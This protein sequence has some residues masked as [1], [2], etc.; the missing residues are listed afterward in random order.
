M[1]ALKEFTA[2]KEKETSAHSKFGMFDK[3]QSQGNGKQNTADVY[4]SAED[5]GGLLGG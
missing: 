2:Q 1:L 4:A 5:H 3:C